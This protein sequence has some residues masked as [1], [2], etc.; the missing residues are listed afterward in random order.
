MLSEVR[1]VDLDDATLQVPY[2]LRN[3]PFYDQKLVDM[4]IDLPLL[5]SVCKRWTNAVA[6]ALSLA[7]RCRISGLMKY[8]SEVVV[9]K[10]ERY[11]QGAKLHASLPHLRILRGKDGIHDV[12]VKTAY[13]V[14]IYPTVRKAVQ[15]MLRDAD[16]ARTCD[17]K[18][19]RATLRRVVSDSVSKSL[20]AS[21]QKPASMGER[22]KQGACFI[23]CSSRN[24]DSRDDSV[25]K[26]E[27][28]VMLAQSLRA[29][30]ALCKFVAD[31]SER[32]GGIRLHT[33]ITHSFR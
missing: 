21:F 26:L 25:L 9:R 32:K 27:S 4:A 2:E 6:T 31:M 1:L 24:T 8:H 12:L 29:Q 7:T 15:M 18:L 30:P 11:C 33:A 19:Y 22:R 13:F 20:F 17:G 10:A 28:S 23:F 16:A 3:L 14:T 5:W